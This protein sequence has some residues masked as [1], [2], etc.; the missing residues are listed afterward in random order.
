LGGGG[1]AV[2]DF[3]D[4]YLEDGTGLIPIAP[5]PRNDDASPGDRI[6]IVVRDPA[7]GDR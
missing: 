2:D 6:H 1:A 3:A 5:I 7:S 4:V